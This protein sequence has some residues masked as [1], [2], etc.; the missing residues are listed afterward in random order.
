MA[1]IPHVKVVLGKLPDLLKSSDDDVLV[2]RRVLTQLLDLYICC[3]DFD[4]DWYFASY[5]DVKQA[6]KEGRFPSGW[7]HF[8]SVGYFEGRLGSKPYVDADWY[9]DTYPDIAQAMLEG[10]VTSALE[11]F[12]EFGYK[13]GRLPCDPGIHAKWYIPRYMPGLDAEGA[14]EQDLLDDFLKRGLIQLAVPA[15]PR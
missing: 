1:T 4:E 9:V 8:R 15:P 12:T 10:K 13:E 2:P 7:S 3:W 5:P 6:V 11:H 14:T